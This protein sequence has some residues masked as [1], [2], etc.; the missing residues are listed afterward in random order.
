MFYGG[1]SAIPRKKVS[2]ATVKVNTKVSSFFKY[3]PTLQVQK[4]VQDR[5]NIVHSLW[6]TNRNMTET[7][8]SLN[9]MFYTALREIKYTLQRLEMWSSLGMSTGTVAPLVPSLTF[10]SLVHEF[11]PVLLKK[12][13]ER[14]KSHCSVIKYNNY[15][16]HTRTAE[17]HITA[18]RY[19]TR[20]LLPTRS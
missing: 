5:G 7:A 14:A 8:N 9:S 1:S 6:R 18:M 10:P 11:L 16:C 19:A 4:K 20:N 17:V 3:N 2:G 12:K 13:K 15:H